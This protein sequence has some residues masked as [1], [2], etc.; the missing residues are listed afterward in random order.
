MAAKN[1]PLFL[2]RDASR[3]ICLPAI[4]KIMLLRATRKID[5]IGR[6]TRVAP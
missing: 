4:G 5:H 3:I 2:D 1:R 6:M